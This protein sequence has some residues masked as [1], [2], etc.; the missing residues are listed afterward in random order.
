MFEKLFKCFN[1]NKYADS[2][3]IDESEKKY[4][5]PDDYYTLKANEGTMFEKKVI[6]FEERKEKSF[7]SQR[8]LY[9]GE[10]ILLYCCDNEYFPNPEKGYPGYLWFKYGIRDVG[11]VLRKLQNEGFIEYGVFNDNIK[12]LKLDKLK[13]IAN[14][15]GINN[16]CSKSELIDKLLN[17]DT[18]GR[19]LQKYIEPTYRLN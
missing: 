2:K 14:C 4:Y 16:S 19:N 9:V 13:E 17:N 8:G 10:I 11:K 18:I 3:T 5:K 7:P 12:K 15:L 1:K 6:T